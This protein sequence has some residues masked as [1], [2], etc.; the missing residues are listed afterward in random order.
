MCQENT[1]LSAT[2]LLAALKAYQQDNK[3]IPGSLAELVPTYLTDMPLDPYSGQTFKYDPV[4]KV[5][6]SVGK[7][8]KDVGGSTGDSW[9]L[10]ENPTFTF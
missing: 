2:R 3:K 4:K 10:M 9:E 7:D 1:L 6:Y 8:K 5:I